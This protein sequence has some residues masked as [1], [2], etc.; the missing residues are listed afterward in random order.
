MY[1]WKFDLGARL[2]PQCKLLMIEC[3]FV[4]WQD[5]QH[6]RDMGKR[7]IH[8]FESHM[9]PHHWSFI[10]HAYGMHI[11]DQLEDWGPVREVW[12][13]MLEDFN[14]YLKRRVKNRHLPAASIVMGLERKSSIQIAQALMSVY[15]RPTPGASINPIALA[16]CSR[17]LRNIFNTNPKKQLHLIKI[18]C[19]YEIP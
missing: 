7:L 3:V 9:S 18:W 10:L 11:P 4:G 19:N 2:N 1:N 16:Y 15:H 8:M 13:F 12:M 5:I 14:G 6:A 17:K